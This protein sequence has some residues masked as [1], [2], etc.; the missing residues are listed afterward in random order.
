MSYTTY[1]DRI[2]E[3]F[4]GNLNREGLRVGMWMADCCLEPE[5]I[6]GYVVSAQYE[7][8]DSPRPER[9]SKRVLQ[10][11]GRDE[12]IL[13]LISGEIPPRRYPRT[14]EQQGY[15]FAELKENPKR[16]WAAVE[17]YH[18]QDALQ[19]FEDELNYFYRAMC[20]VQRERPVDVLYFYTPTTDLIGHCAMYCDDCD[21]LI[22]AYQLLD[23]YI[24]K[25]MEALNP[26]NT[27]VLSDH[28][29]VNF[30]E[31]VNCTDEKV[32][33]EAFAASDE[34]IWL[35]NGYIAFE[36]RNGALLFTAHGLKG[37][38]IASGK[39]IQNMRLDEMQTL[40][41][42]P[43]LL[44]LFGAVIPEGREGYVQDIF[45]RPL[46]NEEKKLPGVLQRR[47]AAVLQCWSPSV[48]DIVL[49]ELYIRNRFV[50][51]FVVGEEKYREIFQHNPRI[52]GFLTYTEF[53]F[54]KFD[55]VYCGVYNQT[56]GLTQHVLVYDKGVGQ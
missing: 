45:S 24:G 28:G 11:C 8:L 9:T 26:K 38:F 37:L 48:T 20:A 19:N 49:N 41:I 18:F 29:M 32:R 3:N 53:D 50:D 16:A 31:L 39:S 17:A 13:N 21:V 6:D 55:Q 12:A 36:A 52:R 47:K 51:F 54:R 35:P 25:W 44:E 10:V 23:D 40:D 4:R 7:M 27:V 33:R 42:Y 56:T 30:K 5:E 14:L 43:T 15:S 46:I 2:T 22:R 1:I 34:V